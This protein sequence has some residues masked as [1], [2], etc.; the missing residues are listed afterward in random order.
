M[1]SASI[2]IPS[3]NPGSIQSF[4]LNLGFVKE[5]PSK[6]A[7]MDLFHKGHYFHAS[8][9][10]TTILAQNSSDPEVLSSQALCI[11]QLPARYAEAEK[12]V[13]VAC[14]YGNDLAP[15][16]IAKGHVLRE[17]GKVPESVKLL[18]NL[19]KW[20]DDNWECHF[21][22]GWSLNKNWQ[23]YS[24]GIIHLDKS[25]EINPDHLDT[26]YQR[27]EAYYWLDTCD[28]NPFGW[29]ERVNSGYSSRSDFYLGLNSY[30]Q[31]DYSSAVTH[32][33]K[34]QVGWKMYDHHDLDSWRG[35]AFLAV[36]ELDK[37]IVEFDKAIAKNPRDA[38]SIHSKGETLRKQ[39]KEAEGKELLNNAFEIDRLYFK[40][41]YF[42]VKEPI[43]KG[44]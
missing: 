15:F 7:A 36:N 38:L 24:A 1:S 39:G 20:E 34:A 28:E 26:Y 23:R 5:H 17:I 30:H 13:N 2:S 3:I 18:T 31:K 22:L 40:H 29:L 10:F 35:E 21:E 33:E 16:T 12:L 4:N 42:R 32:F 27:G 19:L 11:C 37:A 9:L 14:S 25:L 44:V 8:E 6:K 43:Q 41:D